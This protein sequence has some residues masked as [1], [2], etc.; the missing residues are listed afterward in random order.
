MATILD[1]NQEKD[2]QE[3]QTQGALTTGGNTGINQ[4]P[5]VQASQ[6]Q[7]PNRQG[8]GRFTNLQKYLSANQQAGQQIA[9]QV[10]GKLQKDISKK[11]EEA[12]DYYSKLGQSIQEAKTVAGQGGDFR[13]QLQNIGANIQG[14]EQAGYSGQPQDLGVHSFTQSPQFGQFQNIQAGRGIDERLLAAQQ[15]DAARGAAAYQQAA[16]Q[17]QQGLGS[18]AGRFDLLKQTFGGNVN[19]Q[20]STGAQRLDQLFLARQGLGDLQQDISQDVKGA[21]ELSRQTG[22][23]LGEVSNLTQQEQQLMQDINQQAMANE[24]AYIDLLGS[25]VPEVQ[26]QRDAEWDRLQDALKQYRIGASTKMGGLSQGQLDQLGVTGQR[27]AFDVLQN[28]TGAEDIAIKGREAQGYQDVARQADVDRYAAL[29][30]IAGIEPS[31]LTEAADLGATYTAREGDAS[32]SNRLRQAQN[33][34]DER[35]G[36]TI[37]DDLHGPVTSTMEGDMASN[38]IANIRRA[39]EADPNYVGVTNAVASDLI[40]KGRGALYQGPD[41]RRQALADQTWNDFQNWL[42]QQNYNSMIGRPVSGIKK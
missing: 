35:A 37:M 13:Q 15:M 14:A 36:R 25:Y 30:Q 26:Q 2:D 38:I 8:S 20:Y 4:A 34:F 33:I 3:T 6:G 22:T 39:Q 21:R 18:E 29:A 12:Q 7:A 28:L 11:Q 32:L 41:A 40:N 16:T 19:P 1:P 17:A 27:R 42:R 9:G 31:R 10:G 5:G 23:T 24:Q